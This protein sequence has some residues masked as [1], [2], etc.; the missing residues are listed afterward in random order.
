LELKRDSPA[1]GSGDHA[2]RELQVILA[3][4]VA[5]GEGPFPGFGGG[6]SVLVSYGS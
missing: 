1:T 5:P 3:Q 6:Q 4:W 2:S